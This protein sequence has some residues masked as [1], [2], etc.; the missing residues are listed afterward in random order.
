M[1]Q[2]NTFQLLNHQIK[3]LQ[4]IKA[5]EILANKFGKQSGGIIADEMGLGK[6]RMML[7]HIFGNADA[8]HQRTLII[9]PNNLLLTHWINEIEKMNMTNDITV[10]EYMGPHR[11]FVHSHQSIH[12]VFTTYHTMVRD[13]KKLATFTWYRIILDEAQKI[14]NSKSTFFRMLKH[15]QSLRKWC[16][17]STPYNNYVSDLMSICMFLN[18]EP[19]N[20]INW[21]KSHN[22]SKKIWT[23]NFIL[24]RT[25]KELKTLQN[26]NL[27]H[28]I[29]TS[30]TNIQM[31][32]SNT[33]ILSQIIS[34]LQ[35]SS[36]SRAS[37][38]AE[39]CNKQPKTELIILF[40]HS[41]V[42]L[43]QIEK[44]IS[45]YLRF[46]GQ[47][48]KKQEKDTIDKF[49]NK[50]SNILLCTIQKLSCGADLHFAQHCFFVDET[51]NPFDS[52]QAI[53]RIFRLG[54]KNN[55]VY[56]HQIAN[57]NDI[58]QY[59]ILMQQLYKLKESIQFTPW[60]VRAQIFPF[61]FACIQN[62]I[63][64]LKECFW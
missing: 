25:H 5:R 43:Q 48:T 64:I 21:W 6:T 35:F 2:K 54:Q 44:Y 23:Q 22:S 57:Q 4:W 50:Q 60:N 59:N 1:D 34:S 30:C 8:L 15:I 11:K 7:A 9:V 17:T 31:T 26:I 14:R 20:E 28:Q 12:L 42:T 51:M 46:Y 39:W 52:I 55:Q 41:I 36:L 29:H 37:C 49:K 38:V 61:Y 32:D 27:V 3:G 33:H 63:N 62:I 45:N 18:I 24:S 13:V 19:Y 40:S 53:A 47:M 16:I 56:V 10:T 58:T